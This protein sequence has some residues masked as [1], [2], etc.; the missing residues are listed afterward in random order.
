MAHALT[1]Q[2]LATLGERCGK[3]GLHLWPADESGRLA[4]H[5]IG[6]AAEHPIVAGDAMRRHLGEAIENWFTTES[7]QIDQPVVLD[8]GVWL[9]PIADGSDRGTRV[10][11]WALLLPAAAAD[12]GLV[13]KL[14]AQDG[15]D[16][17]MLHTLKPHLLQGPV[18]PAHLAA[19]L[20]WA[21]SDLTQ[22]T[23]QN[24]ALEEFSDQL[25]QSYEQTTLL[26]RFARL[27]NATQDARQ[28]VQMMCDH[29]RSVMELA[30]SAVA[31]VPDATVPQLDGAMFVAGDLPCESPRLTAMVRTLLSRFNRNDWTRI[32]EPRRDELASVAGREVVAEPITHDD[33]VVGVLLGANADGPEC[34][35]S[36]VLTQF[37]DAASDYLG[38]FHENLARFEEQRVMFLG[39]LQALTAAIDAKDRYTC[40]HTERVAMLSAQ[41]AQAM[42]LAAD[43]VENVR[44][45]GL[46]HDVGKIGVPEAVL[47]KAGRLTDE[48]FEQI[49][50]HPTIGYNILKDIPP[51][52]AML[53]GVLYHHERWDGRGYPEGLA[54]QDI[55]LLG[56]IIACADTFDAMRSTRSYRSARSSAETLIE[57]NRCAGSQFDPGLIPIFVRMDFSRYDSMVERHEARTPFAA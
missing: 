30:W 2:A 8:D 28:A 56:R 34:D 55:P 44:I 20:S 22:R 33:R 3:L 32:L 6:P 13:R 15:V 16:L 37:F 40:G 24:I 51:L 47:C 7:R 35:V 18:N 21:V 19:A 43:E 48:E 14:C 23:R 9:L 53:P 17:S 45:A 54:G 4:G 38:V 52:A 11:A 49:K 29:L 12:G 31:F 57:M 10:V 27:M 1:D 42:G 41:L 5:A 46:V 36:S 39:T 25:A 26:Y 50:R